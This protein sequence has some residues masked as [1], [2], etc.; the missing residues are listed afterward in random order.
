M[1]FATAAAACAAL[2]VFVAI[3]SFSRP[4]SPEARQ[5]RARAAAFERGSV[6]MSAGGGGPSVLRDENLAG[7][8]RA[9]AL[10]ARFQW[11]PRMASLLERAD[12]PLKVS[13]LLLLVLFIFSAVAATAWLLSGIW[14]VG[15][16]FGVAALLVVRTW[17]TSRAQRRLNTFNKQLPIALHIMATSLRSGFSIMESVRTVAQEME[18]PLAKEFR[19]MLDEARVGSSFDESLQRTVERVQSE[20]LEVV[21]RALDI[22][23]RVG[24][25]LAAIL[26][27]VSETMR[28]REEL[29]GHVLALTA[30]QRFGGLIVGLLPVWV[31][32]FLLV[33]APDFISPLWEEPL[34][35]VLLATG[36]T[37]EI[38]GFFVM[39]QVLKIEV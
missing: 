4:F 36:I 33:T 5:W 15:L 32:G 1:L 2:A 12:L 20:D 3:A 19:R 21:A 25:D 24:G 8:R 31:V 9:S 16:G 29:R 26:E 6:P 18:N 30:Q 28:Q 14:L 38:V 34:G 10:L 27:S 35:R 23:R 22:H 11:A 13:E 17:L 39:R 7:S 37:L